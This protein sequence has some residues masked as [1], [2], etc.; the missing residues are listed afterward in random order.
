MISLRVFIITLV[1]LIS[2]LS[3]L[4]AQS[5]LNIYSEDSTL[6]LLKVNT[7]LIQDSL[8]HNWNLRFKDAQQANLVFLD[9]TY[10][11]F[12]EKN[13]ELPANYKRVYQ[14][15]NTSSGWRLIIT[16]EFELTEYPVLLSEDSSSDISDSTEAVILI[17]SQY[18]SAGSPNLNDITALDDMKFEREKLKAI[19]QM[20]LEK[21]LTNSE[22]NTI[23]QKVGFED[24]RAELIEQYAEVFKGGI[25]AQNVHA[26]FKLDRY[27]TQALRALG[28]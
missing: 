19:K 23:L 20:L 14:L 24:K 8:Q 18:K 5:E 10:T 6:F 1:T 15:R 12:L 17:I 22:L 3:A 13:I 28:L 7:D 21:D 4:N 2:S 9:S 25:S 27:R 26:L 11:P 16:S